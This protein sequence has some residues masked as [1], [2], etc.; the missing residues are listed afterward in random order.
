MPEK[1]PNYELEIGDEFVP[2]EFKVTPE[3]NQQYLYGL[4]D[5]N[6][7]YLEETEAGP[8]I[9]HPG[10]LLNQSNAPR[11]VSYYIPADAI[12]FHAYEETEFYNPGRVGKKFKVTYKVID[13]YEKKGRWYWVFDT[14]I[15][16][17][18]GTKIL[19]RLVHNHYAPPK[20]AQKAGK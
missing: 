9:V 12:G 5:F 4:E 20:G 11:S 15:V 8:P 14:R 2:H 1:K 19:R 18:D 17:E 13:K 7:Q 3:F 16:D 6:P 10:L